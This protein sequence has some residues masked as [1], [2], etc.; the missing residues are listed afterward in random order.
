MKIF[1]TRDVDGECEFCGELDELR[2]YGANDE[3]ICFDCGE[4][5]K[6]VT[7][8]KMKEMLGDNPIFVI[9]PEDS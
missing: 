6:E 1:D 2:P 7:E 9:L 5:N 8:K 3:W 4:K